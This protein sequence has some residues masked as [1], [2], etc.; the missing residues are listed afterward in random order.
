MHAR[1][2]FVVL[3]AAILVTGAATIETTAATNVFLK[4]TTHDRE[5]VDQI[6]A[7][8]L[9]I[10]GLEPSALDLATGTASVKTDKAAAKRQHAPVVIVR[11]VDASSPMLLRAL[12]S[13]KPLPSVEILFLGQVDGEGRQTSHTVRLTDASVVAVRPATGVTTPTEEVVLGYSRI[14]V[15]G[16]D[17]TGQDVLKQAFV[18]PHVLERTASV[19]K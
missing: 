12:Q 6:P 15:D 1:K 18:T 8:G 16:K 7:L 4:V 14:A 5:V 17:V 2:L 9:R 10:P 13:K 11:S 19:S 3:L